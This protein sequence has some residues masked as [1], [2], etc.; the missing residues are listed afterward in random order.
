MIPNCVIAVQLL[1]EMDT[2]LSSTPRRHLTVRTAFRGKGLNIPVLKLPSTVSCA[3]ERVV[4][5]YFYRD[6]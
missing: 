2:G 1:N 5:W 4:R 3:G 6:R